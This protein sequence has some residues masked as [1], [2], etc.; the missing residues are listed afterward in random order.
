MPQR[1]CPFLYVLFFFSQ[2]WAEE[3]VCAVSAPAAKIAFQTSAHPKAL[4]IF[5][6]FKDGGAQ[7]V[8]PAWAED[9]FNPELPGSFAHF[10]HEMSRGRL[11]VEGQVL[12]R[13][14]RSREEAGAYLAETPG[15]LGQYGRFNLEILTA[16]DADVDF[17]L[18]DNDGVDGVP[19]S[20]DDDGYVDIV[21][22][23]LQ[24]VPRDFFISTATGIASL[25]LDADYISN[26]L[27]AGG[28][29]VRVRSRFTGFGGTTQRGHTFSVTASTMCHEFAH[30]LGLPDLFDQTSVTTTGELDPEEDSAGIGKWGIMGLGTLGWGVEDGPNAFSAWSLAALGWVEVV[31]L[32]DSFQNLELTEVL[33]GGKVYKIPLTTDEYF[34]LEHRR[35][36]GSYYNRNIP[37]DGLLIWHVDE[38]ADNDEERHKRVDLVCADGLFA[39]RGFPGGA[40]DPVSGRDN[41]DFWSRDNSYARVHNGNQG[42]ATDP[43]DGVNFSRFA[44]DTNP[45]FSAHTGFVRRLPLG[46]AVENIRQSGEWMVVDVVRQQ[47]EGHIATDTRWSGRVD[48]DADAVVEP[49]A[50]LAIEAGTEIRFARGDRHGTGFDPDRSELI[51][52]G[53]LE[54]GA[55]V[56]FA[57]SARRT[58]PLDWSGIYLLDGQAVDFASTTIANAHRRLVRFRLPTGQTRW[59]SNREIH[60]DLVIPVGAE[61]SIAPG[62]V[63]DFARVDR[64]HSGL[65]P[66]LV[67]LVVEGGLS[68][69]GEIGNRV[70]LMTDAG[71][72]ND[73]LWYG[74]RVMPGAQVAVRAA[75]IR[76]AA[77]GFSGEI[78]SQANMRISDSVVRENAGSGMNLTLNGQAEIDR[79]EFTRI[80]GPALRLSGSG[81]L[82]LKNST[83]YDNGQEGILLNNAS[84]EALNVKILN[85]GILD[86]EDPRSG[87]RALGGRGQLVSIRASEIEKNTLHG[88]DL[89]EWLGAVELHQS[90]L[91]ANGRDGLRALGVSQLVFDELLVERNLRGGVVVAESEVDIQGS[92]FR[93]NID[94]GLY[95][96]PGSTGVIESVEF[97]GGR[98][99]ELEGVEQM[100]IRKSD[101]V[102]ARVGLQSTDSMPSIEHNRFATNITAI[103]VDGRRVPEEIRSNIFYDNITAIDNLSAAVLDARDNY[104]STL[105]RTAIAA[106]IKGVVEWVPFLMEESEEPTEILDADM[107]PDD[108]ALY[109][110]FPNPF[111]SAVALPFDLPRAASTTLEIYDALGRPVRRLIEA[112]LEA[113]SYRTDWDG[114]DQTGQALAS[115]VYFYRLVSDSF[116]ATGRLALLR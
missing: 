68:I 102:N 17:G 35:A 51:V 48:L 77:Y 111:N 78:D 33:Q 64:G 62:V 44:W 20:G 7:D 90:R 22:I 14:Y 61:L 81:R 25:G 59:V 56:S 11:R 112:V 76:R 98:G 58:G 114:Y 12:P 1:F 95:L 45:A 113:G 30:V 49:G 110:A 73:G 87:L 15:A 84:L 5:A 27:A 103:Q 116:T 41:L 18:F 115:G 23:N 52:Y 34:L 24:T 88:I 92:T 19:N 67:E 70:R 3:F 100:T 99:L 93:A 108:F 55:G 29:F 71:P 82:V 6:Q 46:V 32:S 37:Q 16:A 96:G 2:A 13:R 38:R 40:A 101:F 31:E 4:V 26:D 28:G 109:P 36:S 86:S 57:S 63:V 69:E 105:D 21:F 97:V 107:L 42:D 106:Q 54:I 53:A 85:S 8:S 10:Y 104:W 50:R 66:N 94:A 43:F 75:Q 79:T 83:I 74:I 39:D 91:G 72:D 89:E 80:T 65:S 9:L 47:L 60:A